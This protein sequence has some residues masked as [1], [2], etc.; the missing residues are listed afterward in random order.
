M[1][2]I[3]PSFYLVQM[4]LSTRERMKKEIRE[5]RIVSQVDPICHMTEI[6]GFLLDFLAS[7]CSNV[8]VFGIGRALDFPTRVTPEDK[9]AVIRS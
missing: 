9:F 8:I 2:V 4:I 3:F 7:S 6:F 5:A 1:T